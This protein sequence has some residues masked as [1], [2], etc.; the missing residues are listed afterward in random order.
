MIFSLRYFSKYT[1][2]QLAAIFI[3]DTNSNKEKV[4]FKKQESRVRF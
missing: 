3:E 4:F 2:K 1:N